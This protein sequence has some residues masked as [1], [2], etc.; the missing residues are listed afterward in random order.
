MFFTPMMPD[1]KDPDI[2]HGLVLS[3]GDIV[4]TGTFRQR[5]PEYELLRP[6]VFKGFLVPGR[7]DEHPG[8]IFDVHS[9]P[10]ALRFWQPKHPAW[11]GAAALHDYALESGKLSIKEANDLYLEA[12]EALGVKWIHR[13][14][15]YRGVEF[16]RHA[17][18]DRITRIDPSNAELIQRESGREAIFPEKRERRRKL[19]FMAVRTAG[20]LYLKTKG[21]G[22]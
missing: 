4:A 10:H 7:T 20:S 14:L 11:W 19:V 18:P 16:A 12:M 13:T 22:L 21:I 6:V 2:K 3:P 1:V 15:A 17:F 9:L 8:F 5:R